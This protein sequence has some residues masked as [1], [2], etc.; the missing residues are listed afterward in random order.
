MENAAQRLES[1][2][3]LTMDYIEESLL[4]YNL[5]PPVMHH[6][7]RE[8]T[9]IIDKRKLPEVVVHLN[10]GFANPYIYR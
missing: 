6:E 10:N 1:E 8:A 9:P 7:A 5:K 4:Q 2:L 3:N